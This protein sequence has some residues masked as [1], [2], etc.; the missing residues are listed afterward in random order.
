MRTV[1]IQCVLLVHRKSIIVF[2]NYRNKMM[3][4]G[5]IN[6]NAHKSKIELRTVKDCQATVM[7]K[8]ALVHPYDSSVQSTLL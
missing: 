2:V 8:L 5:W 7:T 3:K 4:A 1:W 6:S